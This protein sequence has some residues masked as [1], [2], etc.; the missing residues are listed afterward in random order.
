MAILSALGSAVAQL[1][2]VTA[3]TNHSR[4]L[5]AQKIFANEKIFGVNAMGLKSSETDWSHV[6]LSRL[7]SLVDRLSA[8]RLCASAF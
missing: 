3:Q 4:C 1:T 8:F 5:E 7:F 2:P 6:F